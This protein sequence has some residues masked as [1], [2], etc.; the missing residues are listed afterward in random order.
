M[1]QCCHEPAATHRLS[2]CNAS[3][4]DEV[5]HEE[6]DTEMQVDGGAGPLYGAA[7]L[8]RQ[9][10]QYETQQGDDQPYLG[11]Q[12]E[13]KGVLHRVECHENSK[14]AQMLPCTHSVCAIGVLL[15]AT[16]CGPGPSIIPV[17]TDVAHLSRLLSV[18]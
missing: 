15:I 4:K 2:F 16:I 3:Q 10:A 18:L 1:E 5:S 9:D 12:L 7:E 13:P 14:A 11:H 17:C 6:A 8:E